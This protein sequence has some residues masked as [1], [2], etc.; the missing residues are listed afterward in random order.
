MYIFSFSDSSVK[1]VY[2][3]L[4]D[5]CWTTSEIDPLSLHDALPICLG[6]ANVLGL[7][8]AAGAAA[9]GEHAENAILHDHRRARSEEHTSELQS[10]C[11]L[12]CRLLLEKIKRNMHLF[13]QKKMLMVPDTLIFQLGRS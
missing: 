12:V 10:H 13:M 6:E 11:N 2:P 5:N 7:E 9:H 1:F 3:F 4:L 8:H